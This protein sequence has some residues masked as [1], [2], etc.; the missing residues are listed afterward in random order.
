MPRPDPAMDLVFKPVPAFYGC[1]LLRSTVKH[2]SLYVGSTPNPQ[3]RLGQHN[4]LSVGGAKRTG[5]VGLR[6]WEMTCIVTDF[7]SNIAA[8][9]FE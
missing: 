6:P 2:A 1:Y 8:L 7:P 9:Q 4:G 3:R 5:N